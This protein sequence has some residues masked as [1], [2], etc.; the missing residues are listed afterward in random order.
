MIKTYLIDKF[1]TEPSCCSVYLRARDGC[2]NDSERMQSETLCRVK[3][4][5]INLI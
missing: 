4:L 2:F 1:R 3:N 5:I